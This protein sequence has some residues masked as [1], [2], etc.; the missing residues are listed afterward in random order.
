[1]AATLNP[2]TGEHGIKSAREYSMKPS[3]LKV[4]LRVHAGALDLDGA[5]VRSLLE[6]QEGP[7]ISRIY[8]NDDEGIAG[9]EFSNNPQ[10]SR[11]EA[12]FW[13]QRVLKNATEWLQ[14]R[15]EDQFDTLR[16]KGHQIDLCIVS[17][18]GAIPP[19]LLRQI[20]RL[21]LTLFIID[22]PRA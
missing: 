12:S 8:T 3:P 22:L 20:A 16:R 14:T 4:Q 10:L 9:V 2:V 19:P 17:Y 11:D 1:M 21:E 5:E 15:S 13:H 18:S 7:S 6:I